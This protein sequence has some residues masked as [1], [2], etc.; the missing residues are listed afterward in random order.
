MENKYFL[1][2]KEQY[3]TPK[4]AYKA[5]TLQKT[6]WCISSASD[7]APEEV[8]KSIEIQHKI[9]QYCENLLVNKSG[10][11]FNSIFDTSVE[12][13]P[14][15]IKKNMSNFDFLNIDKNLLISL[16]S[17][18]YESNLDK[19]AKE[20]ISWTQLEQIMNAEKYTM[21]PDKSEEVLKEIQ[22]TN[23]ACG[24]NSFITSKALSSVELIK[25]VDNNFEQLAIVVGCN[26]KQIGANCFNIALDNL[27]V[28]YAGQSSQ[29]FNDKQQLLF[30]NS[31]L[32]H[33]A[34]A[35]EWLHGIDNMWVQ[36]SA[37][38]FSY[39]HAS[40]ANQPEIMNLLEKAQKANEN[41]VTIIMP[42]IVEKTEGY[43]EQLI[44]RYDNLGMIEKVDEC[45]IFLKKQCQKVIDKNWDKE[46]FLEQL[47]EFKNDN[48]V[49]SM[50]AYLA[51]E[52][53]LLSNIYHKEDLD[54]SLFYSYALKMDKNLVVAF[55]NTD[56]KGYSVEKCE[57]FA[58][59]YETY[60]DY[61][62]TEKGMVN[63]VSD[64]KISSYIPYKEEVKNYLEEWKPVL[65]GIRDL[66]EKIAPMTKNE[67]SF[68]L[69][70]FEEVTSKIK[71]LKEQLNTTDLA[72][73]KIKFNK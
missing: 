48:T 52:L 27:D 71:I 42:I 40:E 39:S 9:N 45:R 29:H 32:M 67:S 2:L 21:L 26:K 23:I 59:L 66:I 19:A 73:D 20:I 36:Q 37:K 51:T 16:A 44:Q 35:H 62:L 72:V 31:R 68:K 63:T 58:R 38:K 60:C 25:K 50:Q 53:E 55:N 54:H 69:K 4:E 43:C 46:I 30:L 10:V 8:K 70:P 15:F 57:Q 24:L 34:F 47:K 11:S 6:L 18:A 61:V 64:V 12:Q 56:W 7:N 41:I 33:D 5:F 28:P 49:G 1:S 17:G 3:T 65:K 14:A 22:K 13:L